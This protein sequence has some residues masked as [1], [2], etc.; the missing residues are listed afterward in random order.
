VLLQAVERTRTR[1][2]AY[3]IGVSQGPWPGPVTIAAS[4]RKATIDPAKII[5]RFPYRGKYST[6]GTIYLLGA[7]SEI[8]YTIYYFRHCYRA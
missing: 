7:Q 3:G 2:L 6:R 4:T 1:L 5:H 8:V